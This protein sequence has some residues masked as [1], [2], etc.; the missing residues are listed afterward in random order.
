MRE[1]EKKTQVEQVREDVTETACLGT[2]NRRENTGSWEG[3]I[4]R[5]ICD[6]RLPSLST[7][8]DY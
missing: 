4:A 6:V 5:V 8:V 1:R 7:F 3:S 2:R